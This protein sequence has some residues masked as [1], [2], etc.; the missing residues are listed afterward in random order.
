MM[1]RK[2][3]LA[4]TLAATSVLTATATAS[5]FGP[6]QGIYFADNKT[7]TFVY[8]SLSLGFRRAANWVRENEIDPTNVNTKKAKTH[9]GADVALYDSTYGDTGWCGIT[10][11]IIESSNTRCDHFH[12]KFNQ[13][14]G[15][16]CPVPYS[17]TER[18]SLACEEIAHSLG[19][20]HRF[21]DGTCMSQQWNETHLN[22][23]D[24]KH[25]NRHY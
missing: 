24:D 4:V 15:V 13:S 16:G 8:E 9:S 2:K 22:R 3:R 6:G 21:V 11:C 25:L 14:S 12:I 5:N 18:R 20:R 23:H 1:N 17:A 7:H 10:D 19:L